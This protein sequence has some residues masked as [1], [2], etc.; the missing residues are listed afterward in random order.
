MKITLLILALIASGCSSPLAEYYC[1]F[2]QSFCGQSTTD[3]TNA[4]ASLIILAFANINSSGG[5][6]LDTANYPCAL[7]TQWQA[8]GKKVFL[9]IGG[10]TASWA[11]FFNNSSVGIASIQNI[12]STTTLD[13][14]DLD[15]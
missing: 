3:D 8:E 14:I 15:I 12:F 10:A 2:G 1:T 4:N 5:I 9:S 11:P 7:V 6:V 13:G